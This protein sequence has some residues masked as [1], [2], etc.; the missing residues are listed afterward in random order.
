MAPAASGE[1]LQRIVLDR[2][3][4]PGDT[5]VET[6]LYVAEP[7]LWELNEPNLYRVTARVQLKDSSSFDE[8][9]VRC[10]FRDF[11]FENGYF[12][13]NGRRLLLRCSH[14]GNH[15]PVG[16][17]LPPDPD[18]LRRDLL[19][20]KVMG[21]NAIRFICRRG[22]PLPARPVRR[23]RADGLRGAVTR[24][25]AWPTRRKWPRGTTKSCTEMI[26]RDR[27]H[28]SR[29]DLGTAER[30]ARRAGVSPCTR[31]A[32]DGSQVGRHSHG[33]AE[34]RTLGSARRERSGRTGILAHAG[35]DRSECHPQWRQASVD[36][37]GHHV[38]ATAGGPASRAK[39][40]IQRRPLDLSGGGR[41]RGRGQPSLGSPAL[42]PPTC[43][44][45]TT[46]ARCTTD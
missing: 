43:M 44:S 39:G 9:S 37:P 2:K 18:M 20:V 23:D 40:R 34:Q 45:C 17:Q 36:R 30:D 12:R 41:A 4:P 42:P 14:T 24:A 29:R 5:L 25:G 6:E 26:R 46:A 27:N 7:R 32:A 13:L 10:G 21:F 22:N 31:G 38:A 11:T 35:C 28:P 33:Y 16:L 8:H 15:C 3:L 1:T 19:N